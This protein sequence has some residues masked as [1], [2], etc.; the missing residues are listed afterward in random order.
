MGF[1][2]KWIE[3]LRNLAFPEKAAEQTLD[4]MEFHLEMEI[5]ERVARGVPPDEARRQ[6]MRDFGGVDR[7]REQVR[8]ARWGTGLQDG[9]RDAR[10]AVR[11]L[12]RRPT[13][14]L[15][16]LGT[17]AVGIGATTALFT[18]VDG[19]LLKPL[20]YPEPEQVI[21]VENS[22]NGSP[23]A[24]LS[25]PEHLDLVDQLEDWPGMGS[26]TFGSATLTHDGP[27][28][29]ARVAFVTAGVLEAL[30]ISPA[31]GRVFTEEEDNSA[32][33]V[34]I[35]TDGYWRSRFGA[36]PDIIGKTVQVSGF[37]RE[38][39]GVFPPEFRMP[40]DLTSPTP[41][42]FVVPM[43]FDPTISR[44]VRGN[45]FLL[46]LARLPQG[47]TPEEGHQVLAAAGMRMVEAYPNGYPEDMGFRTAG[48]PL[49]DS[50]VGPVRPMLLLLLAAVGMAFLIVCANV[51]NLLLTRV[52]GRTHELALRKALGAG[53]L[54]IVAQV[55][56]ESVLLAL[57][58]SALGIAVSAAF[59]EALVALMPAGIP[60][61]EDIGLN[62]KVLFFGVGL[63]LLAGL[64]FSAAPAFYAGRENAT[65]TLKSGA[66]STGDIQGDRFRRWLVV[67]QVAVAIVL[68]TGA[69][70]V[71]KSFMALAKVDP[72]FRT[73]NIVSA[74]VGLPS[75]SYPTDEEVI[76]F[77]EAFLADAA[78][79]P[80]VTE[81][82]AVTNLPLATRLG[83]MSF[84]LEEERIPEGRDKPDSDWQ[85]VTPG[86]FAAM[87]V[88]LQ[89]GRAITSEDRPDSRGV[90]VINET[91]AST[92]WPGQDPIGRRIRLGGELTQPRWAEVV[93]VVDDVRHLGLDQPRR[94][95][96]YFAHTQFRFWANGRP[97]R[98]L[99]LV[100]QSSIQASGVQAALRGRLADRDPSLALSQITTIEDAFS[101]S[102]AQPRFASLL[103]ASFS[104]IALVLALVGVY[105][106][107][108][109]AVRHRTREFGVRMALGAAPNALAGKVLRDGFKIT[110]AGTAIGLVAV[111][112][113]SAVIERFLFQVSATDPLMLTTTVL[114]VM[115]A[116]GLASYAPARLASRTDPILALKAE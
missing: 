35:L 31:M 26:Y 43:G 47:M 84:E 70:L 66:Q 67:G 13:Y 32:A 104:S 80:G 105:G 62:P 114:A 15:L 17:L 23:Q 45:H 92:H 109:V 56:V 39:I 94:P 2:R 29:R 85:V 51:A 58:G 60:R 11:A 98:S 107:M 100:A 24:R 34:M 77:W 20:P 68:T 28:E 30:A 54:R 18:I 55:M 69:A 110:L 19:I 116:A 115:S 1:M 106:V 27:A 91:M 22:W 76:L 21:R 37:E 52:T 96:M 36:D 6:A 87:G 90:V 14:S 46:A 88:R 95:Q 63:G 59:S 82:G 83:D 73:E 99:T 7:Y 74:S 65:A 113:S 64:L 49:L 42:Q 78:A 38:V 86:Y 50:L 48:V 12:I 4:E 57:A 44:D 5:Q 79:I 8:E 25:P 111:L 102:I 103:I 108:M 33:A 53:R 97:V 72:G 101:N 3:R 93:G 9:F 10:Y 61:I 112:A 41:T 75:A 40:E 71:T 81:V 16:V 89:R